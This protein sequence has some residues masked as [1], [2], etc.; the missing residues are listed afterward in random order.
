MTIDFQKIYESTEWYGN[1]REN[2]CP[3]VR[4]LPY[5][6]S[7]LKG[8]IVE[9]GCGRGHLV[10]L[11]SNKGFDC[12]GYD[13][14]D[15]KNG[16]LVGDITQPLPISGDVAICIDCIEHIYDKD[17]EGL[18]ENLKK[19]STQILSVHNG[20]SIHNGVELHINKK[21]HSEWESIIT[22][23]GFKIKDSLIIP[24]SNNYQLLMICEN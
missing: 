6:E 24:Q 21:P 7:Y 15:L 19:F 16:M 23:K 12:C 9:L 17:L 14:I 1:A 2:R 4:L 11:L 13:Q 3:S 10:E 18:Y 8:T 20:P 5:F 22:S